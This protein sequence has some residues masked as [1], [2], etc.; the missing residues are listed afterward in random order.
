MRA[1]NGNRPMPWTGKK[2]G[3]AGEHV[4]LGLR[5]ALQARLGEAAAGISDAWR[6]FRAGVLL[7][8]HGAFVGRDSNEVG[9]EAMRR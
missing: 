8:K 6:M 2:S 5:S 1:L 9:Y 3:I 4:A 7:R